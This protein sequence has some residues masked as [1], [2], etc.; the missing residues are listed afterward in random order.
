M[1]CYSG[2][3]LAAWIEDAAMYQP[4]DTGDKEAWPATLRQPSL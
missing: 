1:L 2:H 3:V 4:Q